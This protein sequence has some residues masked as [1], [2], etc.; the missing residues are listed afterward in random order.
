MPRSAR[1]FPGCPI[2]TPTRSQAHPRPT[3]PA[4][5]SAVRSTYIGYKRCALLRKFASDRG[6][7]RSRQ[8]SRMRVRQQC[9]LDRATGSTRE[10]ALPPREPTGK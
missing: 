3:H 2:R 9:D 1:G 7:I 8:V 6:K 5:S 4:P 10:T